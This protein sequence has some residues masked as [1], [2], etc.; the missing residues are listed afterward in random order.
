MSGKRGRAWSS[1]CGEAKAKEP[2]KEQTIEEVS[3]RWWQAKLV[4]FVIWTACQ[5][6]RA[7]GHRGRG[8]A[9]G[10]DDAKRRRSR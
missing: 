1:S 2:T 7:V 5:L 9:G 4:L 6:G 10:E 3:C 8:A